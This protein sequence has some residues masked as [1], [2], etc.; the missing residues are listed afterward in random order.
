MIKN[1]PKQT[2]KPK[3]K[4]NNNTHLIIVTNVKALSNISNCSWVIDIQIRKTY[5]RE[6]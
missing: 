2:K 6:N 5:N 1:T 3:Q 4:Q